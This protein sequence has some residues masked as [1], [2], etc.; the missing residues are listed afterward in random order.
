MYRFFVFSSMMLLIVFGVYLFD[1]TTKKHLIQQETET[2]PEQ[3]TSTT[4][5]IV[6]E[7]ENPISTSTVTS[8][9][10]P[11][12]PEKNTSSNTSI[13]TTTPLPHEIVKEQRDIPES[14]YYT[15]N[16]D[17]VFEESA[18]LNSSASQYFWLNSGAKLIINEGK[19]STIIG[20]LPKNDPWR[21]AYARSNPLDTKNGAYPQ[22]LFR[23]IT[24]KTWENIEQELHFS[25]LQI[26]AI[27]TR[28]RDE[29]SGI[30]LMSRYIDSDNLYYAGIRMDGKAVIKKKY[31]GVYY[32]LA[33]AQVFSSE[34][35]FNRVTNPNLIP[36]RTWYKMSSNV[37]TDFSGTVHISLSFAQS[38]TE[39]LTTILTTPDTGLFW[40]PIIQA[41]HAGIRTDFADVMF[42]EY[43]ISEPL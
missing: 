23:L 33:E 18:S 11:T 24:R 8:T 34:I 3:S 7:T 2:I 10:Q 30:F 14:F 35:P 5:E 32:T 31:R 16:V 17:E 4:S 1:T 6:D 25:I 42:D 15:F 12:R 21:E 38:L 39:P 20:A 29:F 40:P 41:G 37:V 28:D 27:N 26:N 43:T 36:T 19:G 9:V 13:P 22:N